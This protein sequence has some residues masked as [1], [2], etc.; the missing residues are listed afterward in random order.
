MATTVKWVASGR[1]PYTI[2]GIFSSTIESEEYQSST[3]I[4]N[5]D[6]A[7]LDTFMDLAL[8]YNV[9]TGTPVIGETIDVYVNRPVGTTYG[10]D[11][12]PSEYVGSFVLMTTSDGQELRLNHIP[13]P[14]QTEFLISLLNNTALI[15]DT[16]CTL[17]AYFYNFQNV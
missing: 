2:P 9:N 13:V 16:D 1:S 6:V 4:S 15:M 3:A 7:E 5:D 8:L 10:E 14:P 17:K 12:Q 11:A